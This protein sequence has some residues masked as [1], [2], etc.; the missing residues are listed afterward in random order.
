MSFNNLLRVLTTRDVPDAGN[1]LALSP[2]EIFF[3]HHDSHVVRRREMVK[4]VGSTDRPSGSCLIFSS[5]AVALRVIAFSMASEHRA[6]R[7][8]PV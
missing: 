3:R 1:H 8:A 7:S 6:Y 2:V 4:E 5:T